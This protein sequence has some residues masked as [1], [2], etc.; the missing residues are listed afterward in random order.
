MLP[1][2]CD[3]LFSRIITISQI[4]EKIWLSVRSSDKNI[5]VKGKVKVKK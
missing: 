3:T 4:V 1:F 5:C 2:I